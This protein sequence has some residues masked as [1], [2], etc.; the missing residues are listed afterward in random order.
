MSSDTS[1]YPWELGGVAIGARLRRLS[2]RVDREAALVYRQQG[3]EFEQRWFGPLNQLHRYGDM[4]VGDLARRLGISH[5]AVSQSVGALR[6]HG[7]V[8][9]R[10]DPADARRQTLMLSRKGKSLCE[11]LAPVWQ[12]LE[13]VS[14]ELDLAAAGISRHLIM[15]ELALAEESLDARFDRILAGSAAARDLA[16][17]SA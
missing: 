10:A 12:A 13:Q 16:G 5:A 15:L 11:K 7:L 3:I 17:S 9:G 6:R 1:V 14:R 4:S 8:E 2:E